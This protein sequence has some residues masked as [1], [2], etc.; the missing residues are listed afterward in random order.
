MVWSRCSRLPNAAVEKRTVATS[1]SPACFHCRTFQ[2]NQVGSARFEDPTPGVEMPSVDTTYVA[3][4]GGSVY[5][6]N[7][8]NSQ[9]PEPAVADPR[10]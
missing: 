10:T 6:R 3:N 7:L 1:A 2:W 5:R 8:K 4:Q 9:I